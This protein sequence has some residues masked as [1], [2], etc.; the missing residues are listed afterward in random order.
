MATRFGKFCRDLRLDH[1]EL[2]YDMAKKL[3]VSSA[4]LSKVENGKGKPPAGWV[5]IISREYNLNSL[6]RR[7]LEDCIFEARNQESIDLSS[8]KQED[9]NMMISFARKIES[10]DAG[11]K[12]E[13]MKLLKEN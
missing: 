7:E 4:F 11:R 13:L 1:N 3:D 10:L 8:F 12:E 2:L 9:R 6:T 5:D